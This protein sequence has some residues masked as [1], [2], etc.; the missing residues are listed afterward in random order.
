MPALGSP[1]PPAPGTYSTNYKPSR[2][3]DRSLRTGSPSLYWSH[4][5]SGKAERRAYWP[6]M[7]VLGQRGLGAGGRLRGWGGDV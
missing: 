5:V 7:R 4:A 6:V 1:H 2:Q 3:I